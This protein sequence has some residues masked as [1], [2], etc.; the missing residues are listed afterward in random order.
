MKT[1]ACGAEIV[2]ETAVCGAEI[3]MEMAAYGAESE[4]Q[5]RE[6]EVG[7]LRLEEP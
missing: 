3:V 5:N 4:R 1:A 6:R 7:R 2:M